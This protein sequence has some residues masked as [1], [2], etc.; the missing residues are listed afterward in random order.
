MKKI[1]NILGIIIVGNSMLT[2]ATVNFDKKE[3]IKILKNNEI[4]FKKDKLEKTKRVKRQTTP[5]PLPGPSRARIFSVVVNANLGE[6]PNNEKRTILQRI[7]ELNPNLDVTQIWLTFDNFNQDGSQSWTI[8]A[9]EN[10]Q[11]YVGARNVRFHVKP[12]SCN[13]L[14]QQD[15][16]NISLTS[17][18][19]VLQNTDLGELPNNDEATILQRIAELNPNLD[20]TQIQIVFNNF[21]KDGSQSWRIRAR[22]KSQIYVGARNVRFYVKLSSCDFLSQQDLNNI[23]LI[24]LCT[25]LQNTD[26]GEL[27]NNEKRT[28]LQRI[29]ELNPNLDVTQVE[30]VFNNFHQDGSQSWRIRARKNSPIYFGARSARF[31][32]MPHSNFAHLHIVNIVLNTDLG[33]LPNNEKRTILQRIA[34]LNPNLDVTQVEIVFSNINQDG[35]QSWI[36]RAKGK[37]QIYVGTR[38]VRFYVELSSCDFL[39]QQDL[40]NILLI[41][42]CTVLQN[43]DLGKLP[44]NEKRTILQRIAELNPNLDVT[45]VEIVFNNFNQDGSQSWRIRPRKNS[46]IYVGT[47]SVRFYVE[48]SSCD[49]LSQ[50]DLDNILLIPLCTVLQNTD[51]GELPNNDEA[52]ILQRIVELNPTLDITQVVAHFAR[53]DNSGSFVWTIAPTENSNYRSMVQVHFKICHNLIVNYV[54]IPKINVDITPPINTNQKLGW[55]EVI[56]SNLISI[57]GLTA[58]SKITGIT[59]TK[60]LKTVGNY[61]RY[62]LSSSQVGTAA[63]TPETVELIPLLSSSAPEVLPAAGVGTVIG[64]E[65]TASTALAPETFGLSALIGL[66]ITGTTSVIWWLNNG[67]QSIKEKS[68]IQYNKIKKYYNFLAH[69]QLKIRIDS[70]KW[71]KISQTYQQFFN[72]YQKFLYIIK[73]EIINFY[74]EGHSGWNGN[75]SE[76]DIDILIKVIFDN[77]KKINEKYVANSLSDWGIVT[78]TIGSYFSIEKISSKFF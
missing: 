53:I 64:A 13:F 40:D 3:Q 36:I 70:F 57:I 28:I 15:R 73:K 33:E 63:E 44:N 24:P 55:K 39:S 47:R 66:V 61:F 32:V 11:I 56:A 48:L 7:A 4:N 74:K 52:T 38:S 6:L 23:L 76:S 26:L 16:D 78:N 9:R 43:T 10:S 8:R 62:N 31:Y 46:P 59:L 12:S 50:Q 25:V 49:F 60:V 22:R 51:L 72:N 21:N 41:P 67:S 19:T 20:V 68:H 45:Q 69:D 27:P 75:I 42:L 71:K 58:V 17:L 54:Q 1:L 2:G 37:S 77:F 65:A 34:E 29:A 5:N 14:S 18:C 30:I 35:S